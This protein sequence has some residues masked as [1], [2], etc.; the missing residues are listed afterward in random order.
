MTHTCDYCQ[1]GKARRALQRL[2]TRLPNLTSTK[3]ARMADVNRP[4]VTTVRLEMEARGCIPRRTV[5]GRTQGHVERMLKNARTTGGAP[6]GH[7]PL[8]DVE[9]AA[10]HYGLKRNAA[11]VA[12]IGTCYPGMPRAA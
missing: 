10:E 9:L 2:F 5:D 11:W 1:A 8:F 6:L 7:V 12:P 3:A 4:Y